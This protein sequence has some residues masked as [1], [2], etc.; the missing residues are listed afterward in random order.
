MY[1]RK[2]E[3]LLAGA[4]LALMAGRVSAQTDAAPAAGPPGRAPVPR[5]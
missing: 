3:F 5:R 1:M 2:R 4:G